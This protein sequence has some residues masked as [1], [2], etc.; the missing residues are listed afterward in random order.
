[1]RLLANF[2][3]LIGVL[4][5]T[6]CIKHEVI[7]APT[8][9][10]DLPAS[11]IGAL[12]GATYEIIKDVDGYYC[13]ADQSK[14]LNPSP[15]MSTIIYHSTLRSDE[16]VDYMRLEIGSL[17]FN[18]DN[19]LDASLNDF[20]DFFTSELTRDFTDGAVDGVRIFFQDGDGKIWI[21][22]PSSPTNSF[23]FTKLSQESDENGDYMK[24]T[25]KFNVTLLFDT[26]DVDHPNYGAT[27]QI[28]AGIFQGFFKR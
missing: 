16:K 13:Q 15:A 26:D 27:R 5:F 20:D 12:D 23:V 10:V 21:S 22:D 4:L 7:P 6:S 18:Q 19:G 24:F 3:I 25:A 2:S 17:K 8:K 14:I 9:L 28:D 1:M 11:F